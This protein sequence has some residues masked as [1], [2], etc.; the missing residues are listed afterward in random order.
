[1][2]RRV[3]RDGGGVKLYRAAD[4][5]ILVGVSCFARRLADARAY[6]D[7]PGF[8]GARLWRTEVAPADGEVLDLTGMTR[9]AALVEAARAAGLDHPGSTTAD[10]WI[11]RSPR[12]ADALV[13]AGYRWVRVLDTYPE[14][15]ETWIWLGGDEDPE[16]SEVQS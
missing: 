6:L 15:C 1:M 16:L 3:T 7:N 10:Q 12:V 11:A 14:D 13:A 8:G 5:D 9:D 4:D 2:V